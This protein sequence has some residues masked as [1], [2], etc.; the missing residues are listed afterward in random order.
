ME[1][2]I[3]ETNQIRAGRLGYNPIGLDPGSILDRITKDR[4]D[5]AR[6]S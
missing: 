3:L 6:S 2:Y 4:T 5:Q 1:K